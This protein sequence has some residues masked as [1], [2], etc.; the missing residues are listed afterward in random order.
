MW[1]PLTAPMVTTRSLYPLSFKTTE[2]ATDASHN[3]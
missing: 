3:F 2:Q 1:I